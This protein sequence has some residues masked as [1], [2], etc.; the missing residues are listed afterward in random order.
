M[1]IMSIN[2]YQLH[3]LYGAFLTQ[4]KMSYER[5]QLFGKVV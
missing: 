4:T 3:L 2:A 1:T 5:S